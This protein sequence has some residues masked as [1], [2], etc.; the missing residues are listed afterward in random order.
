[1]SGQNVIPLDP[2]RRVVR[3]PFLEYGT[4]SMLIFLIFDVMILSGMVGAFMLTRTATGDAWP[5]EGQPWFPPGET[6]I[7][8]AALLASGALVYRA[9]GAWKRREA[10]VTPL[11]LAAIMLGIFFIFFQGVIWVGLIRQGLNLISTPHGALFC[12]IVGTHG[13]HALAAVIFMG[14]TWLRLKPLREDEEQLGF[15][16]SGTFS[17]ARL[18]WDFTAGIWPILYVCLYL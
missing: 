18:F 14:F 4:I 2:S 16:S 12:L 11:L 17:A 15:L 8:T 5:P 6:A 13:A 3:K 1:M 10:Q 7:N 9:A